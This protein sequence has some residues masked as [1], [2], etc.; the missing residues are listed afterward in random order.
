MGFRVPRL[1]RPPYL[2][3]AL[4]NPSLEGAKR[5]IRS[6]PE[7]D[8]IILEVGTPLLK[9]HGVKVIQ[10]LREIAKDIFIIA[11]LR[12]P[13]MQKWLQVLLQTRH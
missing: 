10:E 6:L 3:I 12:R 2:Q 13:L 7:S 8:R 4:D 5:V 9:K 1:W 11:D